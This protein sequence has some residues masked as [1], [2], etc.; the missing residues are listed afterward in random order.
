MLARKVVE[1][2]WRGW[3]GNELLLD[4]VEVFEVLGC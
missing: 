3:V 2:D 1:A 4:V